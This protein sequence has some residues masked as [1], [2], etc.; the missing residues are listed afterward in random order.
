MKGTDED[1]VLA[2]YL[3]NR[4]YYGRTM[5][6]R[7]LVAPDLKLA[8]G[9]TAREFIANQLRE[10]LKPLMGESAAEAA[11]D[12]EILD[13]IAY[14]VFPNFAPW[15]AAGPSLV[16][17]FRPNGDDHESSIIDVMFLSPY[18]PGSER[19]RPCEVH[20]L[21][22]DEEWTNAEELGRLGPVLNQDSNNIPQVQR[23]LKALSGFRRGLM[24][25]RYQESRIRHFHQTLMEYVGSSGSGAP[26]PP[27]G[28]EG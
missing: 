15:M 3:L 13:P 25:S 10:Q 12:C 24:M 8:E 2:N 7:D 19:P 6:G 21:A 28:E 17:R 26:V 27:K 14:T 18:P 16:Y 22:E 9:Q 1:T 4:Q 20:W 5:E 11:T 23:G